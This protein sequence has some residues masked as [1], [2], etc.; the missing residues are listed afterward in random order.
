MHDWQYSAA[1]LYFPTLVIL[2]APSCIMPHSVSWGV[3]INTVSKL[4]WGATFAYLFDL[5]ATGSPAVAVR[6][7][8]SHEDVQSC[9][10]Q[11]QP[12]HLSPQQKVLRERAWK[13]IAPIQTFCMCLISISACWCVFFCFFSSANIMALSKALQL[14]KMGRI[15][16][17]MMAVHSIVGGRGE[18]GQV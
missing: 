2:S 6:G 14:I 1:I 8:G 7:R 18:G 10:G 15:W 16:R 17:H 3:S 12:P 9:Q 11:C 5:C 13:V 4:S